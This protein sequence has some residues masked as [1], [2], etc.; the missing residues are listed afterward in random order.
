LII[1]AYCDKCEGHEFDVDTE[2][3]GYPFRSEMFPVGIDCIHSRTWT[4]PKGTVSMEI[5]C[6]GC[7]GF[8]FEFRDGV[9]SGR[10]K[11]DDPTDRRRKR[12]IMWDGLKEE[13]ELIRF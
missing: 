4:M 8:P 13:T 5:T 2:K 12:L 6:P 3:L 7:G 1:P 11:I 9:A 10:I